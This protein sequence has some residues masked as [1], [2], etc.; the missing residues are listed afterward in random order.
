MDIL[1]VVDVQNDFC[2]GGSLAVKGGDEIVPTINKLLSAPHFQARLATLDWHPANHSS[3]HSLWPVH[4]V[5]GTRGAAF[6]PDLQV[7]R[8]DRT[9]VKGTDPAVDSYSGFFD[10]ERRHETEL[11][12]IVEALAAANG[13][14]PTDVH[15]HIVGLA[16]DY[17]VK[18]T[19]LDAKALGYQVSVIVD[20]TR[21]V[22][23]QPGDDLRALRELV[24][25]GVTLLSSR[26]ILPEHAREVEVR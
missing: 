12:A 7:T 14:R 16:L 15:L 26:D 20:A 17:C 19:A 5:Q 4:C 9:I 13:V 1:L 6:H 3:F 24:A 22:H 2:P 18:A 10:N 23:L 11:R 25:G 21:A 8:L